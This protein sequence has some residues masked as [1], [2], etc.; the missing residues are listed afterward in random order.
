MASIMGIDRLLLVVI[1]GRVNATRVVRVRLL[2]RGSRG[3]LAGNFDA[4]AFIFVFRKR[5][6][7]EFRARY[8]NYAVDTRVFIDVQLSDSVEWSQHA[9]NFEEFIPCY[10]LVVYEVERCRMN[11]GKMCLLCGNFEF[12]LKFMCQCVDVNYISSNFRNNEKRELTTDRIAICRFWLTNVRF[13][14]MESTRLQFRRDY[15]FLLLGRV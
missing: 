2:S 4:R 10:L 8:S 13:R 14:V 12:S 5:R 11:Y 3:Q 15:Y 1:T 7:R 6:T 9:H